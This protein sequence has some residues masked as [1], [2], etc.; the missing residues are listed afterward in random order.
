MKK[1][2]IEVEQKQI[3]INGIVFDILKSDIDILNDA[4][5]MEKAYKD[6][7]PA[8]IGEI[9][10]AVLEIK[11]YIDTIL[12]V[13]ALK[14]IVNNKPVSL[15]KAIEIMQIITKAVAEEYKEKVAENYE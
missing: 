7:N 5:G 14:N 9:T 13:G 3:E 11:D 15:H 8:D 10:K 1:L 2:T 6:L 12:G 4:L